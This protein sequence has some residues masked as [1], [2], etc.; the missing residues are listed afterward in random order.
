VRRYAT[1]SIIAAAATTGVDIVL[2]DAYAP[3]DTQGPFHA[4]LH[5]LPPTHV[6][7]THLAAYCATHPDLVVLDDPKNVANVQNRH[8]M[9][10]SV[11]PGL[12]L[13]RCG[14]VLPLPTTPAVPNPEATRPPI[15]TAAL[16][17]TDT[18]TIC[19][20][21]SCLVTAG[22]SKEAVAMLLASA[23]FTFPMLGKPL[24][25]TGGLES[26]S[27]VLML[28][29]RALEVWRPVVGTMAITHRELGSMFARCRCWSLAW[30]HGQA[31][32]SSI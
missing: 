20:P 16:D 15:S 6:F 2:L 12:T 26:H 21:R 8:S 11:S 9:L 31:H 29:D 22:M 4:I 19:M 30:L 18:C 7:Y 28:D 27:L 23:A 24:V 25:A 17:Q 3:L 13:K 10:S 5:K 1:P 14:A 32:N